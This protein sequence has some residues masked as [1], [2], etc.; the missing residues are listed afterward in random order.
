PGDTPHHR[1]NQ[2]GGGA[3]PGGT[4]CAM[5]GA[6]KP[7]WMGLRRVP[8]G[9]APPARPATVNNRHAASRERRAPTIIGS[10]FPWT[11]PCP[12]PP[13]IPTARPPPSA[14]IRRPCAA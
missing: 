4:V 2:G 11:H 13:S 5:D 12:V 14:P 9:A 3:A 7:P 10:R 1:D 6:D 8:T